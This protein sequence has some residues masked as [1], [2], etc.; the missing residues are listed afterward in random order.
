M[1]MIE[2]SQA[3]KAVRQTQVDRIPAL[4]DR[5]GKKRA[6]V[7]FQLPEYELADL[8]PEFTTANG[9][10]L[11]TCLNNA[12]AN[13]AKDQF[14]SQPENWE[15]VPSVESLS[16]EALATSFE[17]VSRGRVLTLENAAKLAVWIGANV[18]ALVTGIQA[19]EPSFQ[20]TQLQAIIGVVAKYTAY[21]SKSPEF[22]KKVSSRLGQIA[23]AIASSDDLAESF[24]ADSSLVGVMDALTRK[25]E[26]AANE[27]EIDLD[28]L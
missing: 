25:F 13:L 11:L 8:S 27:D 6:T 17:S 3:F 23:E 5:I 10:L 2:A 22:A 24:M 16:L 28:A 20:A 19:S 15:F 12:L 9:S 21:E 1:K 7:K 18:S 4:A 26:K 14:A